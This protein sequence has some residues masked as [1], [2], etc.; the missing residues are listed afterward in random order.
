MTDLLDQV[1]E[2][3]KAVAEQ[4]VFVHIDFEQITRY[5]VS[6]P[7]ERVAQPQHDA[8][9]HYLN[10]GDDTAAFF[11]TLDSINFG[12]GY[13]PYL[14]KR[15]GMSGYFTV[16]GCLNDYFI[17]QGVPSALCLTHLTDKDCQRIFNQDSANEPV[18]ELMQL[19][20]TALNDLGTY[21]LQH[22]QGS[23]R[24]LLEAA[25]GSAARLAQLL[26]SMKYFNDVE[27]YDGVPIPFLKRA[28]LTAA[29]LAIAFGNTGLGKFDDLPRLTMFADN[30]VPHVL[31]LDG[32]LHY[33]ESLARRIDAEQLIESGSPEEVEIRACALHAVEL[34][35]TN[36]RNAGHPIAP[37][38]LDYL[39]WNRGQDRV[40]KQAKP[41]HRTRTVFY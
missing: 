16:A 17:A 26:T 1:R 21:L 15:P 25:A 6:L 3:C 31:R 29:D 18:M 13:F 19:F 35:S 33:D 27:L 9:C 32:V 37:M 10:H 11:I 30:L 20:A 23:F 28:Q 7:L 12:S 40:Y 36:L 5:S 22:F 38:Q 39:L 41:R 4:A 34:I 24:V 8:C 2:G 14:R